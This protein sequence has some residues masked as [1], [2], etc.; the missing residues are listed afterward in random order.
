MPST[1]KCLASLPSEGVGVTR[2]FELI[3]N[4]PPLWAIL[5]A[6]CNNLSCVWSKSDSLS[7]KS[8]M[9]MFK[10]FQIISIFLFSILFVLDSSSVRP[11]QIPFFFSRFVTN[12]TRDCPMGVIGVTLDATEA[13]VGRV[14][15]GLADG[16]KPRAFKR[17]SHHRVFQVESE[18]LH[19][20]TY[21]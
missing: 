11:F 12:P 9:L 14:D 17:S 21:W 7:W 6:L 1:P 4:R 20:P 15:A 18:L 16:V 10:L 8:P 5:C 19:Q 3:L 13:G 2:R